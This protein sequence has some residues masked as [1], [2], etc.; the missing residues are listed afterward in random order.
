MMTIGAL[1]FIAPWALLGLLALPALWWLLRIIP[2]APRRIRFPAIRL[3]MRLVNP[4]ESSAKTPLWLVI[5]RFALVA[6]VI[7]TAA[8]PVL[9]AT[10]QVD[11][12][13]PLVLVVDDG[14]AA[15]R[16]WDA[17]RTTLGNLIDQAE[18]DSRAVALVTTAPSA[19][20]GRLAVSFMSAGEARERAQALQPKPWP[21]DRGATEILLADIDARGSAQVVWL[22]NGMEMGSADDFA[23]ALRRIGTLTVFADLP[24]ALPTVLLPPNADREGLAVTAMRASNGE[25][26]SY[27]IRARDEDGAVLT[28]RELT[29]ESDEREGTLRL[30]L[31]VEIRNRLDQLEI[32]GQNTAAAVVL[33]DERWRRRP[34]G[35]ISDLRRGA[36]QPLLDEL[37]YLGRALDPFTEV[38]TGPIEDLL[39]RELSLMVLADP[40]R[41]TGTDRTALT[42]W[43]ETGGVAVR[44]AGPRLAGD[45]DSLLPVKL[46]DGDRELG[47]A[48]SWTKPA[49]M[50]T[51]DETSPFA[52][53]TIP[54]D[55][56]IRRQ[57]L[58]QP[59]VDLADKTWARLADGTPLVTAEK[60]GDGWLVF[61]H[62]TAN[63]QWSN[64]P[65]SGLFV[66]MLQQL[67]QLGR[68]VAAEGENR[69]LAPLRSVNGFGH[70]T[71]PLPGAQAI[72][73]KDLP[74]AEPGPTT[75]P[76]FY[77]DETAR[78]AF[79]LST[80]LGA[81]TPIASL[82]PG[83]SV[84]AYEGSRETDMRPWVLTLA[85]LIAIADVVASLALRGL[86]VFNRAAAAAGLVLLAVAPALAQSGPAATPS[87][88]NADAALNVRLAYIETG[89]PE[90]DEATHAGLRGLSFIANSRT[91]AELAE[92]MAVD[93]STDELAF[94]PLIY[95]PVTA[96]APVIPPTAAARVNTYLKRGGTILFDTRDEG[97]GNYVGNRLQIMAR[98]L[99]IPALVQVPSDHV[100]T[101]AYYL[102]REFPGRWTGGLV[103]IER[104]GLRVNDG[105]SSVIVGSHDWAGAWAIDQGNKPLY[106]VVPGGER[107]RELAYRFG[108]NLVMYA[109]TGNYKADQVHLPAILERLGQ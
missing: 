10:N 68:G 108:I 54:K 66:E 13:G 59:S 71:S 30:D 48:L 36:D 89:D 45:T 64:L 18:R 82:G 8:H 41:L 44:F 72:A 92:P 86:F 33:V 17:R 60:M 37:F 4:E 43:I 95:W 103:W 79:N 102:L 85:L 109:L 81:L 69:V 51:F 28:R 25:R 62:V 2:P 24:G 101:K 97:G 26:K 96:N 50:A 65:L 80:S 9:N 84:Q 23:A 106:P 42:Q 87:L 20:A 40:G 21:V 58:A 76:G 31:P 107:Q 77:G 105:V 57:V 27:T 16:N 88:G 34:V 83:V 14:W 93:P 29:I 73:A 6:A 22:S 32:E 7:V 46:R 104:E 49:T 91:A 90:I 67:V 98:H 5:L 3:I 19:S 74:S 15:A 100:L 52:G 11:G 75:P 47:G 53:L 61:V 35:L 99:D 78:R 94:F 55:I 1:S 56:R 63:P 39:K 70:L 12:R 38:R